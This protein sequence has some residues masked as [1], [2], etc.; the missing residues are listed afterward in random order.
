MSRKSS[1]DGLP[2][3]TIS[4]HVIPTERAGALSVWVQGDLSLAQKAESRDSCCVFMTVHDVGVNHN[5]W[6]RFVNS[7]AMGPI[8]E[9]AVFLHVD[10]LGQEDGGE[11]LTKNYPTMQEIGEDLVNILDVMRVKVV[12]GLAEGAGANALLRFGS[13]HVSRC[14]GIVCINPNPAA[15]TMI[16]GFLGPKISGFF[17]DRIKNLRGDKPLTAQQKQMNQKN[18][19]KLLEAFEARSDII[20]V[21]EKSKCETILMAGAKAE[22]HVKGIDAIFS[23]SDKTRTSMMKIDGVFTVLDEAPGKLANAI[24][25]FTKGLGWL[26]SVDLPNVERRSSRDSTGGRRMSMEEYDTPN[27]RRLSLTGGGN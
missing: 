21:V 14:L 20:P 6:L 2:C 12:V 5:S 1:V 27:I 19:Q 24:L 7:P 17:Q 13:M 3:D 23:V 15:A 10:L 4:H 9:K 8:R 11:E 26:T 25:L 22:A 16:G 18:V